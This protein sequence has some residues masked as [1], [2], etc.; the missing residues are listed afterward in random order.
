MNYIV[1][2]FLI[3]KLLYKEH[4]LRTVRSSVL[5]PQR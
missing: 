1:N 2:I 3:Y 4:P 5:S